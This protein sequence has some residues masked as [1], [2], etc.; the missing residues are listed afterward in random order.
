MP[1]GANSVHDSPPSDG[2]QAALRLRFTARANSTFL[3]EREHLGPLRVQRPFY[4][5]PEVC[6]CYIVHPP[7]GVVGGDRLSIE[8]DVDSQ[9]SALLTTPAAGK[10]YRSEG[11]IASLTQRFR[12][13]PQASFE[14]LPQET[15]FY[16][17][18]RVRARTCVEL[19]A[20]ATFVGWEINCLG[21]PARD[22]VFDDGCL[23]LGFEL[24][25]DARP[26]WIDH[27]RIDGE[28]AAR[29]AR[30][31]LRGST[32]I[33][34]MLIYPGN[35]ALQEV[36][37][38]ISSPGVELAVTMVDGVLVCRAMSAQAEPIRRAFLACWSKA[39][40]A[41]LRREAIAPRIWAT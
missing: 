18:A 31:G 33:G 22:E 20:S 8:V 25:I 2:W 37:K 34:T 40:R 1:T 3:S 5:E 28:G 38:E 17:G 41:I 39:R 26:R 36:M 4:P 30:W 23:R 15:I 13:H 19:A 7:G 10:S 29:T 12:V 21:L 6:H 24:S 9:A 27:L 14:W 16:R 32:A 11:L 35:A